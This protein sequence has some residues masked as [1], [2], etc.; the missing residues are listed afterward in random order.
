MTL[1][2]NHE[3]KLW[4]LNIIHPL[5]FFAVLIEIVLPFKKGFYRPLR[6]LKWDTN[7]KLGMG[8]GL[9]FEKINGLAHVVWPFNSGVYTLSVMKRIYLLKR[10]GM[11]LT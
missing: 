7:G 4:T 6:Q 3:R 8:Q 9:N 5:I 10:L 2:L 1:S 11:R